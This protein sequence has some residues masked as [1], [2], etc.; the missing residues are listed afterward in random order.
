[1]GPRGSPERAGLWRPAARSVRCDRSGDAWEPPRAATPTPVQGRSVR[2]AGYAMSWRRSFE[3]V[4]R[5][6]RPPDQRL[7]KA[8][9]RP[10][11]VSPCSIWSK[12]SSH[13]KRTFAGVQPVRRADDRFRPVDAEM[14][15]EINQRQPP[16]P[17]HDHQRHPERRCR[18]AADMGGE[19]QQPARFAFL[20]PRHPAGLEQEVG[21]VVLHDHRRRKRRHRPGRNQ[22][23]RPPERRA[24]R[25]SSQ[26]TVG[27]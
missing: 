13:Q 16:Q 5:S 21:D 8:V 23:H 27:F 6:G 17:R 7:R 15:R 18:M 19:R 26:A 22:R 4:G 11:S 20:A 3:G 2:P 14:D 9:T 24:S 10:I 25:G 1:M 12:P